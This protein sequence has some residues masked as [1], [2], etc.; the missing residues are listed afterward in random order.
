MREP[1][2]LE[3][4][5]EGN[6][7]LGADRYRAA[8]DAYDEALAREP[9]LA[10]AYYNR[11]LA[12]AYAGDGDASLRD[13][14]QAALHGFDEAFL[15]ETWVRHLV[16][17]KGFR[18]GMS[19]CDDDTIPPLHRY[20]LESA[21]DAALQEKSFLLR[22]FPE[23]G[24]EIAPKTLG[25]RCAL[26]DLLADPGRPDPGLV[27]DL[28]EVTD[29]QTELDAEWDW[30]VRYLLGA[31]F[32][33][34]YL[35]PFEGLEGGHTLLFDADYVEDHA[36]F[37]SPEGTEAAALDALVVRRTP[38]LAGLPRDR[39][40][41]RFA[42]GL[43][44]G[45]AGSLCA[46]RRIRL[47]PAGA[48]GVHWGL[49]RDLWRSAVESA[50]FLGD[51]R[52]YATLTAAARCFNALVGLRGWFA[53][54]PADPAWCTARV[55]ECFGAEK[56][57]AAKSTAAWV[58]S[59]PEEPGLILDYFVFE[60]ASDTLVCGAYGTEAW[61]VRRARL[62]PDTVT[63]LL[64]ISLQW[65]SPDAP[66]ALPGDA[67]PAE[68]RRRV[69]RSL[70]AS[71]DVPRDHYP[72]AIER[73]LTDP[74]GSALDRARRVIVVPY[75]YLHNLPFHLL[76]PLVRQVRAGTLE[77][78]VYL[79][80][81]AFLDPLAAR[82]PVERGGARYLFVGGGAGISADEELRAVRRV[83]PDA[84]TLMGERA[85]PD[86]VLEA[87]GRAD[88]AHFAC[89]GGFDPGRNCSYLQ[90]PGGLLYPGDLLDAGGLD[91][92]LVLLNACVTGVSATEARNG[93]AGLGLPTAF[94]LGGAR[95][96]IGALW[97]VSDAAALTFATRFLDAWRRDIDT[98]TAELVA[99]VQDEM[100]GEAAFQDAHAWG[101]HAVFGD[102]R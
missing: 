27:D 67:A 101:A 64:A 78:I 30:R 102:W 59:P 100:R 19:A 81:V 71:R 51:P 60:K 54:G 39:R 82:H 21:L 8:I 3:L 14:R 7:H 13:F 63:D 22:A 36:F 55:K 49:T 70:L 77:E 88:V 29:S 6:A 20:R 15:H 61:S 75:G 37:L 10:P 68:I 72:E 46:A 96:V 42:L 32:A 35:E 92:D 91:L 90:L 2:A 62:H 98:S 58:P 74:A 16:A 93:D 45:A 12:H 34:V 94:L 56:L 17:R 25:L 52:A 18:G 84:E 66:S 53:D 41:A 40:F 83:V 48:A 4:Y 43:F 23:A 57:L 44:Q 11:A 69:W 87:L 76:R 38:D 65:E 28:L 85:T 73:L 47:A 33:S 24:I 5:N 31:L 95:Q 97:P 26:G 79:P 89:H 86:S 1:R 99:R 50:L 9:D 80:S